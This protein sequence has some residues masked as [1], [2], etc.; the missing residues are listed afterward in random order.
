MRRCKNCGAE[1]PDGV[2]ECPSCGRLSI[3]SDEARLGA[4]PSEVRSPEDLSGASTMTGGGS[5]P[6]EKAGG[7]G[8]KPDSFYAIAPEYGDPDSGDDSKK[9]SGRSSCGHCMV[10]FVLF[11]LIM[12]IIVIL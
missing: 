9:S 7:G 4:G 3:I 2:R 11:S 8:A 6:P 1:I 12:A 10:V 5:P